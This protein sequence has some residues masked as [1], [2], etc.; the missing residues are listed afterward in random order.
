LRM[1]VMAPATDEQTVEE[2]LDAIESVAAS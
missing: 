2:L 1:T